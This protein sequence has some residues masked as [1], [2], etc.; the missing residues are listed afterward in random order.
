MFQ[1]VQCPVCCEVA[2]D[3]AAQPLK[4]RQLEAAV[5]IVVK[6]CVMA[7]GRT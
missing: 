3:D 2:A 7:G 5:V 4:L 1:G 6:L